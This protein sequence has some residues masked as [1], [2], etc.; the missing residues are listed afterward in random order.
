M[1]IAAADATVLELALP[2]G[3][4]VGDP[5]GMLLFNVYF[6]A[7]LE[8]LKATREKRHRKTLTAALAGGAEMD[9]TNVVFADDQATHIEVKDWQ[10]IVDEHNLQEEVRERWDLES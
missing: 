10:C 8:D 7:Y 5:L 3:T 1:R 9:V 2:T 4:W 6:R